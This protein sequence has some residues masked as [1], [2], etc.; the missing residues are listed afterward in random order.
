[1]WDDGGFSSTH[2]RRKKQ[3]VFQAGARPGFLLGWKLDSGEKWGWVYYVTDL[4]DVKARLGGDA[5]A[6]QI[7]RGPP[8][9]Y[10]VK[11]VRWNSQAQSVSPLEGAHEQSCRGGRVLSLGSILQEA[12]GRSGGEPVSAEAPAVEEKEKRQQSGGG[13]SAARCRSFG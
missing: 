11:E 5:Q 10:Q 6:A 1:M 7:Q 4:A 13:A 2:S 3:P 8:H 9:L 12:L